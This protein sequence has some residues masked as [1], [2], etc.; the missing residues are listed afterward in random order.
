LEELL[1][2]RG[3]WHIPSVYV[4]DLMNIRGWELTKGMAPDVEG[5]AA[6]S[7]VVSHV[8]R[9]VCVA[10]LIVA[11]LIVATLIVATLIVASLFYV[12]DSSRQHRCVG[13]KVI[14]SEQSRRF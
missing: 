5:V 10:T 13:A 8:I 2:K 14:L 3:V 12:N 4:Q 1:A 9:C 6:A 11:T 7:T